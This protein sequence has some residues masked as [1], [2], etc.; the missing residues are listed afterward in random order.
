MG[1]KLPCRPWRP[2]PEPTLGF[3]IGAEILGLP[4]AT[5]GEAASADC[6]DMLERLEAREAAR[7]SST[8]PSS[9]SSENP[10]WCCARGPGSRPVKNEEVRQNIKGRGCFTW[11]GMARYAALLQELVEEGHLG[12][13]TLTQHWGRDSY[14]IGKSN[15]L[16]N[17]TTGRLVPCTGQAEGEE[18][19][20]ETRK[21]GG[22]R[23]KTHQTEA[24]IQVLAQ[25]RN[26]G[27]LQ[28]K[29]WKF[30]SCAE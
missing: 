1:F 11:S 27:A 16:S 19:R 8:S 14:I 4:P 13:G 6:S 30:F 21:K 25:Q 3:W 22:Y 29:I 15:V 28:I 26:K 12:G 17:P 24:W 5:M 20:V 18:D 2:A 10:R 9:D 7:L 23:P